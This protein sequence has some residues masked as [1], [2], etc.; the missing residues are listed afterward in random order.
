VHRHD[1]EP[2]EQQADAADGEVVD[3][4]ARQQR[5]P[6]HVAV[7]RSGRAAVD[8]PVEDRIVEQRD[9]LGREL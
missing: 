5:Q 2:P 7:E 6:E 3:G 4:L 8:R 1:P 9:G